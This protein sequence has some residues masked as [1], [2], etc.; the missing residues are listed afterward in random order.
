VRI[1]AA[2]L[3]FLIFLCGNG[4]PAAASVNC[5]VKSGKVA[6]RA[7]T[8]IIEDTSSTSEMRNVARRY[9]A[10]AYAE[11]AE[12]MSAVADLDEI[13]GSG[14]ALAG[15]WWQRGIAEYFE[16]DYAKAVSDIEKA[17]QLSQDETLYVADFV[18]SLI[19]D[20]RSD[21]AIS[22]ISRIIARHHAKP[23]LLASRGWAYYTV[24]SLQA[25]LADYDSALKAEPTKAA[26]LNE[27]GLV[28]EALKDWPGAESDYAAAVRI[29]P[30]N[31]LFLSNRGI[32]RSKQGFPGALED[33][34]AA[35]AIEESADR[36]IERANIHLQNNNL[37]LAEDDLQ[38][39]DQ[40]PGDVSR[41]IVMRGQ[42]LSA[43]SDF[44][45]AITQYEK[46]LAREPDHV[47]ARYHRAITNFTRGSYR[48]SY[49]EFTSLVR[50]YPESENLRNRRALVSLQ[51]GHFEAA[52]DDLTQ[53]LSLDPA[54]AGAY[55]NR[56]RAYTLTKQ[57]ELAIADCNTALKLG[58][59]GDSAL[60][61]FRRGLAYRGNSD[62]ERAAEDYAQAVRQDA[63][64]ADAHAER[65]S[66][67]LELDRIDE[68]RAAIAK[69]IALDPNW[70]GYR[71]GSGWIEEVAGDNGAALASYQKAIDLNPADPWGFEG[72]A[73]IE[74]FTGNDVGALSD[75]EAMLDLAPQEAAAYRCRANVRINRSD[76][77]GAISDLTRAIIMNGRYGAAY[78]DRG[79][80]NAES[81]NY[82]AAISDYTEAIRLKYRVAESLILRGD[83]KRTLNDRKGAVRDYTKALD[84]D[85]GKLA[86]TI[87]R[88]IARQNGDLP[89]SERD[90]LNYPQPLHNRSRASH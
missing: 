39:A 45:G 36:Y 3:S 25:A 50:K 70:S 13:I 32:F 81:A 80:A 75:C 61:Y 46:V 62:L 49:E 34:T 27:R 43:K 12:Y 69:A 29:E 38:R 83:I 23:E 16:G 90:E 74:L 28:R 44:A 5:L 76:L 71:V 78:Y 51:M 11:L 6:I 89:E 53:A 41:I 20:G 21:E 67:L 22:A 82:D 15:D 37:E 18:N 63:E 19:A 87:T 26:W 57:W 65:A 31:A 48:D 10:A 52:I 47:T 17:M 24:G 42:I 8:T 4:L 9:R 14:R 56:A 84:A 35:L 66:V 64:F 72:R 55:L 33:I 73:W 7:C 79:L 77:D 1:L 40:L 54:F 30:R 2:L 58:A 68:A 59:A 85:T 88:R 86:D 60:A